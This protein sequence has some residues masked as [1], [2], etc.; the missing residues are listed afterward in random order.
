MPRGRYI[1]LKARKR[2]G[3]KDGLRRR[4]IRLRSK[5]RRGLLGART[6]RMPSYDGL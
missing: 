3:R 5:R 6:F 4:A 2:R 1:S